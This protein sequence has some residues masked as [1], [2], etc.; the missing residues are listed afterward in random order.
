MTLPSVELIVW[1]V[2]S[3]NHQADALNEVKR[4]RDEYESALDGVEKKRAEFHQAVTDL[5]GKGV[6][7]RDIA[8]QLGISHQR[9]HQ[10]VTGGAP[11]RGKKKIIPGAVAVFV[12]AAAVGG[13]WATHAPPFRLSADHRIKVPD[14]SGLT[15]ASAI[16]VLSAFGL[17]PGGSARRNPPGDQDELM[18]LRTE[19][20]AG[21]SVPSGTDILVQTT[22]WPRS[23]G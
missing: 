19:P 22:S 7:L 4:L 12:L 14:V 5:F 11:S 2:P 21:K 13:L 9:V 8:R 10:I 3:E 15:E 6:S 16:R 1:D 23:H 20:S 18:V 17:K